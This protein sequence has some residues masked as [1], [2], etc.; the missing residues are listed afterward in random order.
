MNGPILVC[1]PD[2]SGTTLLYQL[3]ASHPNISMVRRTNMFR[4]FYGRFGDLSDP[5]NLDRCLTVMLRYER[6]G[7]LRPDEHRIRSA[8]AER[9]PSY[10]TLFSILHEQEAARRGKPRWGD[11]SL[12]TEHH[13]ESVFEEWPDA[14]IIHLVRDPRDRHASV[15][16]RYEGRSKGIGSITGRWILS[17]RAGVRNQKKNPHRYSMVRYEDLVH[18]TDRVLQ[19]VC[20]LIGE[21]FD[22]AMLRMDG[23]LDARDSDGNSSFESVPAGTI[24]SRSI[25][26]F[27][28]VLSA[29]EIRYIE[30][31]T[32]RYSSAFGY[33]REN[34]P[35]VVS[36][37]AGFYGRYLP[38]NTARLLGWMAND[39]V[40]RR[41]GTDVP[42]NRLAPDG[43]VR[44]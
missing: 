22:A 30:L 4:W 42:E 23:A 16:R 27:R 1:G 8:F 6:L 34:P 2:R 31:A 21:P 33:E 19:S 12:H 32:S 10:G 37:S 7:A 15:A 5:A 41:R 3:L 38:S 29:E 9:T 11:K 28:S 25:G 35:P 44:P 40:A 17:M 39:V 20:S 26:R 14:T 43:A 36:S 18:D 24:S 13:A